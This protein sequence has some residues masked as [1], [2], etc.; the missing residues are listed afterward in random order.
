MER[1]GRETSLLLIGA[2]SKTDVVDDDAEFGKF[3][4][5]WFASL[6]RSTFEKGN[7][8]D[9]GVEEGIEND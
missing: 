8:K 3:K 6:M 7:S 2:D 1:K 9:V 5:S 4:D